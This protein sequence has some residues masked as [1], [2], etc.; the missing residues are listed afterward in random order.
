L[1]LSEGNPQKAT[2][3]LL[4][5]KKGIPKKAL[6]LGTSKVEQ[7]CAESGFDS[8]DKSETSEPV[9]EVAQLVELSGFV[10][11]LKPQMV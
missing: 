10:T 2:I 7:N 1:K 4:V 5:I 11:N 6:Q 9:E 8:F 3:V